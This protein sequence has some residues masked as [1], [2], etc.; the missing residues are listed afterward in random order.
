MKIA[1]KQWQS[2]LNITFKVSN[3]IF[4]EV[5]SMRIGQ[6]E[7]FLL[8]RGSCTTLTKQYVFR[9]NRLCQ[10]DLSFTNL[11]VQYAFSG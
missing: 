6:K 11:S 4:G 9:L 2:L 5:K 3:W 8:E 10:K 1:M 7:D